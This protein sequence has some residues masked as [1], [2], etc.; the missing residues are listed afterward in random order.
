MV[1]ATQDCEVNFV[2]LA[3]AAEGK[4]NKP[5]KA[6]YTGSPFMTGLF[7]DETT[8][9]TAGFDKAPFLFKKKGAD[10]EFV[11][12]LDEGFSQIRQDKSIEKGSFEGSKAYFKKGE[13]SN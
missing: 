5:K 6:Q 1:Y 10:W 13:M 12:C 3:N 7:I 8:F 11:K 2:D 9:V 4:K